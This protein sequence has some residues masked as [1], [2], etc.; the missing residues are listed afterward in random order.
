[1]SLTPPADRLTKLYIE[2]TTACNLDCVMCVRNFWRERIGHMPLDR[3]AA[4]M[5]QVRAFDAPPRIHL[6][7]YGEPTSHPQFLELVRLAKATGA[8]VEVTTNGSLLDPPFIDAL[9]DLD[10]DRLVVSIDGA[11]PESY[12]SIRE[13]ASFEKLFTNLMW[14]KR[15]RIH[16]HGRHGNPQL[17][18]A[19]VA[20]RSNVADLELLP[21]LAAVLGAWNIM[22]SNVIPHSP[23]MEEEILY[24]RALTACTYRA[25]RWVPAMSLPKL[26]LDGGTLAPVQGAF[27]SRAS[28]SLMGQSL[29]GRN[30]YCQFAQEGYAAVRWDGEMSPCLSL[31]HDHPEHIRGRRKQ[32]TRLSFGNVFDQPLR[33]LW[34]SPEYTTF[35]RRLREFNFSPCTTCGGCERFPA[36]YEDC[37]GNDFPACGGCLWA[38]GFVQC[39]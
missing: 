19:F 27:Q 20:M 33:A 7:G 2:P 10:L 1:M 36:N 5:E 22:V 32:V 14:L 23:E 15:Q 18:I 34:E 39:P 4:L 29:S 26:D 21:R 11:S 25:S 9:M 24:Q 3:F 38:Q 37:T 30:D 13:R 16:R 12:E 17:V 35:R 8:Q 28:I 31:L 6:S